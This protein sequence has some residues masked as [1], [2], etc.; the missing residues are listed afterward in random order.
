[1]MNRAIKVA[2]GMIAVSAMSIGTL[3]AC[4][5]SDSGSDDAKG[6]V[7]YLNYKP[8]TNDA[9]VHK[10]DRRGS[11]GTNRC[12]RNIFADIEVRARQVRGPNPV[13]N[14]RRGRL[15]DVEGLHL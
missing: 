1:M 5:G 13:P 4:G 11:Q 10:A 7:Y 3:A 2:V 15:P 14:Q 8:E 12:V 9:E 6:K